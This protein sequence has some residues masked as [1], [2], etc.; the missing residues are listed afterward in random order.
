[1]KYDTHPSYTHLIQ[2]QK[3]E[4][5]CVP[6]IKHDIPRIKLN[7]ILVSKPSENRHSE[8]NTLSGFCLKPLWL[9]FFKALQ[10]TL[11]F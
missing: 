7:H 1:M 10:F 2:L 6:D 9:S 4:V 5:H 3:I 8:L 11:T